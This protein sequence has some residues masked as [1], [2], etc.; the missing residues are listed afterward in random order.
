MGRPGTCVPIFAHLLNLS[1]NEQI[2]IM[3]VIETFCNLADLVKTPASVQTH[4]LSMRATCGSAVHIEDLMNCCLTPLVSGALQTSSSHDG[5]CHQR[6]RSRVSMR[7]DGAAHMGARGLA[8]VMDRR[9]YQW[10]LCTCMFELILV[11]DCSPQMQFRS[12]ASAG[13]TLPSDKRNPSHL[14]LQD[15]HCQA[16]PFGCERRNLLAIRKCKYSTLPLF[17]W[18]LSYLSNR[19]PAMSSLS[20]LL[21]PLFFFPRAF[22]NARRSVCESTL[23][24]ARGGE[25][26]VFQLVLFWRKGA[27]QS[28]HSFGW[29]G[30]NG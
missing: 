3:E 12:P 21:G 27:A 25:S 8:S 23:W 14:R 20:Q 5:F 24:A 13:K 19:R 28:D 11:T 30:A 16:L 2:E 18:K 1:T 10:L 17:S 26:L 22:R 15:L 7:R 9:Q 4:S 6:F 29:H